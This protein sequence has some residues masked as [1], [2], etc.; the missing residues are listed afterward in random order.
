[1]RA[2]GVIL[3]VLAMT[4]GLVVCWVVPAFAAPPLLTIGEAQSITRTTATLSGT[5]D[6]GRV[7]NVLLLPVRHEHVLWG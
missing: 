5:V 7:G 1:M 4:L 3:T 2:H 6:P